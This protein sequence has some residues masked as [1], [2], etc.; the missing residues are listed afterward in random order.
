MTE[1]SHLLGLMALRHETEL[2]KTRSQLRGLVSE[3]NQAEQRAARLADYLAQRGAQSG[4]TTTAAQLR[5]D[6]GLRSVIVQ[7]IADA[8]HKAEAATQAL[9]GVQ[10]TMAQQ[11]ARVTRTRDAAREAKAAEIAAVEARREALAVRRRG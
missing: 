3:R 9:T 11:E 10:Q 6:L 1:K 2:S 8:L 7:D 4:A 5:A